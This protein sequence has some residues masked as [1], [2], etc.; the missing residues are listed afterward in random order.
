MPDPAAV[1]TLAESLA[2]WLDGE[3]FGV[4]VARDGETA[5]ERAR[6]LIPD[7]VLLDL[8][9]PRLDGFGVAEALRRLHM[10]DVPVI[11]LSAG[12]HLPEAAERVGTPYYLH[13]PYGLDELLAL[14]RRA[15]DEH[16]PSGSHA[17][18]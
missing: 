7:V 6:R 10:E 4:D 9:L 12:R 15:L 1:Q 14:I 13:K 2:D 11:L 8:M 17:P 18:V 16:P 5:I 3:R